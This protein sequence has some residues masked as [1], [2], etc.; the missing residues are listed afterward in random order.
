MSNK[1][2]ITASV[3][4][5]REA[6]RSGDRDHNGS[7]LSL[8]QRQHR[9]RIDRGPSP[10]QWTSQI[11]IPAPLE[12]DARDAI[13]A[14]TEA[15]GGNGQSSILLQTSSVNAEWVASKRDLKAK[16]KE[17]SRERYDALMRDVSG[18]QTIIYVH[19]GAFL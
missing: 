5:I 6:L 13:I 18:Q 11:T 8:G 9:S 19:G 10:S 7:T 3:A 2:L 17:T 14:A 1:K 15:L 16:V 4:K 12:H